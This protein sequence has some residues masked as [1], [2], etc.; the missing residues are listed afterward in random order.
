[1]YI[2]YTHCIYAVINK[3]IF[4]IYLHHHYFSFDGFSGM[5]LT[6]IERELIAHPTHAAADITR[7][8]H[9]PTQAHNPAIL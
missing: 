8:V 3:L 7:Q 2:T 4:N 6:S 9:N 1:M 5:Y